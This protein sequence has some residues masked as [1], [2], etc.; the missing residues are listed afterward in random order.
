MA[1]EVNWLQTGEP[2]G[3]ATS[4]GTLESGSVRWSVQL[5]SRDSAVHMLYTDPLWIFPPC[6]EA[7]AAAQLLKPLQY[8]DVGPPSACSKNG[9]AP[10]V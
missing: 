10:P 8:V 2:G 9:C 6:F 7:T 1:S 4:P 5:A 3:Q